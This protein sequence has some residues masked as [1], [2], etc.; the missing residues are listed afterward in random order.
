MNS[1]TLCTVA[2]A[3]IVSLCLINRTALAASSPSLE[4]GPAK[5]GQP[6]VMKF[7]S[8]DGRDVDVNK[9]QGKVVL[10]DFWATWCGPCRAE[11]PNVKAAYE[12]LHPKG[13]EI[14]GVSFDKSKDSLQKFIEKEKMPWPQYF[15]GLFW[16]NKIGKKY[17][18]EGIP[19]MW[20]VDKK[21][22][23]RNM[24]ARGDLAAKVEKLLA[25]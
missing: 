19:T 13:F 1:K 24:E 16:D 4:L 17:G 8:L 25:E 12:K 20:L 22:N 14:V 3:S 9:L 21:G 18:I 5:A 23:L 7:K 10:I 6:L 2:I 11:L 15:D